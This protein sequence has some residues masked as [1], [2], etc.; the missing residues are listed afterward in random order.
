MK[1]SELPRGGGGIVIDVEPNGPND[2]IARRLRDLGFV[3]GEA[4]SVLAFGPVGSEPILVRIGDAR[5]AL[6]RAEAARVRLQDQ[7]P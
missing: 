2:A 7:T 1:L 5:F 4:V 3:S 6:R